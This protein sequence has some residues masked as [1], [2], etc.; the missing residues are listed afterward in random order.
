MLYVPARM[1]FDELAKLIPPRGDANRYR[2]VVTE[3][4]FELL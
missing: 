1:T 4:P 3:K 2:F